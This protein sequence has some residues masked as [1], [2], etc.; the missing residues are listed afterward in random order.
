MTE[1]GDNGRMRRDQLRRSGAARGL[2]SWAAM[3]LALGVAVVGGVVSWHLTH[4]V[5]VLFDVVYALGCLGAVCLVRP[6]ALFGP[7]AQPPLILL[8]AVP[9]VM[10]VV[11]TAQAGGSAALAIGTPLVTSFPTV[12]ITTAITLLVGAIRALR[13]RRMPAR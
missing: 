12:A 2:P 13:H 11:G 6:H 4:A 9:I 1:T 7:M 10:L 5:G 8:L 3:V